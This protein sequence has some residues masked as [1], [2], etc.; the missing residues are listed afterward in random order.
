MAK[1]D[2]KIDWATYAA[3]KYACEH[4]HYSKTVPA[5]K[6]TKIGAWEDGLFIGVVLF[7]RGAVSNIGSPYSLTQTQVVEL[8]RVALKQHQ[9]NVTKIIR[10]A[11]GLLKKNNPK[12]RLIVSYADRQQGHIGAIY[13]AGNWVYSGLC[14]DKD[15]SV[16]LNGKKIHGRS[17]GAK[18][19]T[20]SILW[21]KTNVD[22]NASP[23]PTLGKH[24]YLYPL[25]AA[26]REQILPL[27]KPYPKRAGSIENDAPALQ[28]DE[29]SV[30]LT[31]A[32]HE[33]ESVA[34]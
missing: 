28:R 33:S 14:R 8:V 19:G 7:G 32:L 3:A 17:C 30:I 20:R 12:L 13:Q 27:A 4:W 29:G 6:L 22:E 18:Y 1:V 34:L 15:G 23:A 21:L 16:I 24:K 25:D 31:P 11:I 2:L 5:G 10:I 26:M 9:T